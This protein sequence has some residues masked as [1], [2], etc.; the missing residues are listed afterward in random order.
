M[1]LLLDVLNFYLEVLVKVS[2]FVCFYDY[3]LVTLLS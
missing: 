1:S 3:K 2:P